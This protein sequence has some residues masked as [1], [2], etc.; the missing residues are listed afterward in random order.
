MTAIQNA[1]QM[2]RPKGVDQPAAVPTAPRIGRPPALLP[3]SAPRVL[4][5]KGVLNAT[6]APRAYGSITVEGRNQG[7]ASVDKRQALVKG[8]L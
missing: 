8:G 7:Q 2:V 6:L 5:R 1:F 4:D 3:G